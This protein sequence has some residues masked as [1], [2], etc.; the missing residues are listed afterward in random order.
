VTGFGAL[1]RYA[2][3]EAIASWS[4]ARASSFLSTGTIT[5]ALFVL[6][7]FLL[8][9]SNLQRLAEEWSRAA[10]MSIYLRDDN[11]A[12]DRAG[13]ELLL[14][15]GGVVSGYEFV[16]KDEALVRF[17]QTF[18]DLAPTV[19]SL[20][21]NPLPAS[22]EVRLQASG[23]S[24]AVDALAVKLRSAAGVADVRY[25][26]QWLDR[27]VSIVGMTR[28]VG[29]ALGAVL[30]VAA[31]LTVGA[32]VALALQA[33]RDEIDIM[34]LVGAPQAYVRGPFV[35]EGLLQGGLGALAALAILAVVF[36]SL[37]GRYL[38][39]LAA[40]VNLSSV[41]FLSPATTFLLLAAGMVVGLLGG[42]LASR[43]T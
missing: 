20:S 37:R 33:R 39:P 26:R 5:V 4:R 32:V 14:Q 13:V 31:A 28:V 2:F 7:G 3:Q 36:F 42:V 6:G 17:K 11:T 12:A 16:S 8:A 43:R 22:Y 30:V 1:V 25:D 40:A 41:R 34:H 24:A 27:L 38:A 9:T 18:A 23:A 10:E 21:M 19:N 35:M 29:L 15:P